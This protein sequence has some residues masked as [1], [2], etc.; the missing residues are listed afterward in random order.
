MIHTHTQREKIGDCVRKSQTDRCQS[1]VV[2][3]ACFLCTFGLNLINLPRRLQRQQLQLGE[4]LPDGQIPHKMS[5]DKFRGDLGKFF[6]LAGQELKKLTEK[7]Q[8]IKLS[9]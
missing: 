3:V 6:L 9:L 8:F 1:R 2:R 4:W 7:K 5:V